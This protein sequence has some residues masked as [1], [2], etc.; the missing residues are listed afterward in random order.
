MSASL[1]LGRPCRGLCT[2]RGLGRVRGLGSARG[3]GN[4]CGLGSGFRGLGNVRGLG[5]GGFGSIEDCLDGV[6]G[7]ECWLE[8][9]DENGV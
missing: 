7:S 5:S 3:L 9:N 8:D 2:L 6:S 4:V 1:G